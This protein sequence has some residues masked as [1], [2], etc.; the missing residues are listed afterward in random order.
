MPISAHATAHLTRGCRRADRQGR[1]EVVDR[2]CCV[3]GI[4]LIMRR[5]GYVLALVLAALLLAC[6]GAGGD[7]T[8]RESDNGKTVTLSVGQHLRIELNSNQSTPY[9]W[10]VQAA[11]DAAVLTPAGESTY[12]PSRSDKIGAP[13]HEVFEFQAVAPG[14]TTIVLAYERLGPAPQAAGSWSATVT[15]R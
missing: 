4:E 1:E 9:R 8:L 5:T 11:P 15:V 12:L 13:G 14:T 6:T 2:V 10:V 3:R 7:R